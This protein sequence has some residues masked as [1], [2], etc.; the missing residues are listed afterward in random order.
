MSTEPESI[1]QF[2]RFVQ[3]VK[4]F[5]KTLYG[6][7]ISS[8]I[9]SGIGSFIHGDPRTDP[10]LAAIATL[11]GTIGGVA[12]VLVTFVG[13]ASHPLDQSTKL[14]GL[15]AGQYAWRIGFW[16]LISIAALCA[17]F[18][19]SHM[20]PF[21]SVAALPIATFCFFRGLVTG[22][23]VVRSSDVQQRTWDSM[24][25]DERAAWVA[26]EAEQKRHGV[27]IHAT[28]EEMRR[29]GEDI[30]RQS[31]N[32]HKHIKDMRRRQFY[33]RMGAFLEKLHS[34]SMS[35]RIKLANNL[36]LL[37]SERRKRETFELEVEELGV[38][39]DREFAENKYGK[40]KDGTLQ[41]LQLEGTSIKV[42]SSYAWHFFVISESI[43]EAEAR[44]LLNSFARFRDTQTGKFST[45][46]GF[47]E[48]AIDVTLEARDCLRNEGISLYR[49]SNW[50]LL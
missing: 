13:W 8:F 28:L 31:R 3:G 11:L 2:S 34:A 36:L 37:P 32:V 18:Y 4:S 7:V 35:L 25:S 30:R 9:F 12:G 38:Q 10:G 42:Y 6:T 39:L 50:Q 16:F 26:F 41:P 47:I 49:T 40:I 27:E 33:M 5:E 19:L 45:L 21:A 43:N 46:M 48:G 29:T 20:N 15:R 14:M 44:E 1:S 24:T 17:S 22:F 23:L